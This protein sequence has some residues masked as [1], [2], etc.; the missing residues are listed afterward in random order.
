M[1]PQRLGTVFV[2]EEGGNEID[3]PIGVWFFTR[4]WISLD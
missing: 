1:L 2:G 3:D 4:H